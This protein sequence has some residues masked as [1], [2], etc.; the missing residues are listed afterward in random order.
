MT[1]EQRATKDFIIY[2]HSIEHDVVNKYL[3]IKF[4][5]N[6]VDEPSVARI[7]T[8]LNIQDF[9]EEIDDEDFDENCL[10][11]LIGIQEYPEATGVRYVIRTEQREIIFF[12]ETEPKIQE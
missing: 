11:S 12:T 4:L 6:P 1:L 5:K 7:L 2:I 3:V 9:S 8:F 10:D